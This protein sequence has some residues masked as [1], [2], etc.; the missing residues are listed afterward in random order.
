[1]VKETFF[2]INIRISTNILSR[3]ASSTDKSLS[4]SFKSLTTCSMKFEI[5]NHTTVTLI[6]LKLMQDFTMLFGEVYSEPY[7]ASRMECFTKLLT[8]FNR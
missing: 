2:W 3:A 1:M 4:D 5:L 8:V 6:K 7:Q